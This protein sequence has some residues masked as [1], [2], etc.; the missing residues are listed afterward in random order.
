MDYFKAKIAEGNF[1][2]FTLWAR[3]ETSPS[4]DGHFKMVIK[5]F[6]CC[7]MGDENKHKVHH[8]HHVPLSYKFFHGSERRA[9][10]ATYFLLANS[11]SLPYYFP[12]S[13]S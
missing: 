13:M 8:V 9:T 10:S 12:S 1:K 5:A 6:L 11:V 2:R 3:D 4:S 7:G